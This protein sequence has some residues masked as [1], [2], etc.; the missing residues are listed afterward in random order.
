MQTKGGNP[1]GCS[2]QKTSILLCKEGRKEKPAEEGRARATC[3][4]VSQ[5]LLPALAVFVR[6]HDRRQICSGWRKGLTGEEQIQPFGMLSWALF[7]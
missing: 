7:I 1:C 2:P 5:Q 6:R 3:A 4:S